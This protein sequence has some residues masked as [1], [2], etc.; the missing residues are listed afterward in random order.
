MP[1]K[2]GFDDFLDVLKKFRTLSVTAL[3]SGAAVPYVAYVAKIAPPW[4]PGIMLLTSL[5]E[6]IC[7]IVTFQ[8]LRPKGRRVINRVLAVTVILLLLTSFAYLAT[9]S[10]FTYVTPHTG[11][12]WVKGFVCRSDV[13]RLYPDECPLV[14]LDALRG[15][16]W[17]A[18]NIWREWSVDVMEVIISSLWLIS[19]ILLTGAISSFIV[20]QTKTPAK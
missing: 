5:T 17:T 16:Q 11:E 6:L 8:F 18:E 15:A 4:P 1:R 10:T 7:I 19:F 14:G 2:T 20:F 12:R 3:G 13:L 9:F